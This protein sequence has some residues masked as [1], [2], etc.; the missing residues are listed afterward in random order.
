[1]RMI[2]SMEMMISASPAAPLLVHMERAPIR[3]GEGL[4]RQEQYRAGRRELLT[5]S[6]EEM[7]RNIRTQLAGMLG[8]A[9]F[10]PARE[11]EGIT[12]NRWGH[13]Y[14]W[15]YAGHSDPEYAQD[16]YPHV[17]GRQ[18]V[19][20]IRIANSDAGASALV[21]SAID[22]AHRAIEEL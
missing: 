19:G 22:Q 21:P 1:M 3:P 14:A 13:G 12:V 6:F 18:P 5:T 15:L 2:T 10:D 16:E 4:S 7:E 17:R 9:G 11:I 20:R 8:E